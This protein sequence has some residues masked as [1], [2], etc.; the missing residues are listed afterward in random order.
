MKTLSATS[1]DAHAGDFALRLMV[2]GYATATLGLIAFL[3]INGVSG[4]PAVAEIGTA[5]LIV[6]GLLL[7]AAGTLR[8]RGA[9]D[10][11][12]RAA[13]DGLVMQALGLVGL[14]LGLVPI[15]ISSSL[16]VLY[17]V[18]AV[19]I[20]VSGAAAL[21]GTF[22]IRRHS[23]DIGTSIGRGADYLILGTVLIFIGAAVIL[24]SNVAF[25]FVLSSVGNTVYCDVGA[26]ILACGSVIA[27]YACFVMHARRGPG[28]ASP[29][30]VHESHEDDDRARRREEWHEGTRTFGGD[31]LPSPIGHRS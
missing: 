22:L 7:P 21:A 27:A 8:L 13:R 26:T 10:A 1:P 14:L 6:I 3:T 5:A 18:S 9:L 16:S 25:Y 24:G 15:E 30:Y 31:V 28:L 20:I 19:L 4:I 17:V 11:N 29:E 12:R 2:E 23:S